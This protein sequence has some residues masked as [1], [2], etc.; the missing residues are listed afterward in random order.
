MEIHVKAFLKNLLEAVM[1][2]V[3]VSL[4]SGGPINYYRI[5]YISMSFS[6]IITL[7]DFYDESGRDAVRNS[8]LF[9]I[10]N[11]LMT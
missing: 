5:L 3:F 1:L 7:Y 8:L 4:T 2:L 11:R 9:S 10:G 6:I